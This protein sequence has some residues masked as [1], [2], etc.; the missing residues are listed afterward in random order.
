MNKLNDFSNNL[1]LNFNKFVITNYFITSTGSDF[2]N[3]DCIFVYHHP[4]L[5]PCA[6]FRYPYNNIEILRDVNIDNLSKAIEL[7]PN[8]RTGTSN[9]IFL[10]AKNGSNLSRKMIQGYI[11]MNN[12]PKL[13]SIEPYDPNV[14][15]NRGFNNQLNFQ[16][17]ALSADQLKLTDKDKVAL[18]YESQKHSS[19]KNIVTTSR[20][21]FASLIR[22]PVRS[23]N[24]NLTQTVQNCPNP[25]NNI[26]PNTYITSLN[27]FKSGRGSYLN[28]GK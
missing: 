7:L 22:Q 23:R 9:S 21:K 1:L 28:S 11:G 19:Q 8:S 25:L 4:I 16:G 6:N 17:G 18:K 12:I 5:D 24:I 10:P 20:K 13:L 3:V 14:I 2:T 15:N 27:F 26:T